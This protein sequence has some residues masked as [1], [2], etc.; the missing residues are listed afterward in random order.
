MQQEVEEFAI[1]LMSEKGFSLN[2]LE[3]YVRDIGHFLDFLKT[4]TV[5]RWGEV[6]ERH[7]VNFLA[8]K[9]DKKYA[10]A[11]IA[12]ALMAIKVFFK[13]LK[14]EGSVARD[15]SRLLV[16]PKVW[17]LI[18]DVLSPEEME[19]LLH[20]PDPSTLRGARDR[21]ILETL[22]ASGL[23][24]SELCGLKIEDVD[25]L[26]VQVRGKGGKERR[27]PI[28][29]QA[30]AAID[31]YLETHVPG[32][33]MVPSQTVCC[34]SRNYEESLSSYLPPLVC[35]ASIGEWRR[36]AGDSGAI[37]ACQHQQHGPLYPRHL[38]A[39]PRRF[40]CGASTRGSHPML[41][42]YIKIG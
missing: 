8:V 30:V 5:E 27:V 34:A 12:R 31:H 38:C 41:G 22:Y 32:K 28:G 6:E 2:T 37:G 3:A 10:A 23:R 33:R 4:L 39:S 24:V 9:K 7:I 35:D 1:Y 19:C 26:Y 36:F 20:Q 18:P 21:A 42:S 13:F 25:D 15:S 17:Q 16:T 11:S 40:S 29:K 14:R